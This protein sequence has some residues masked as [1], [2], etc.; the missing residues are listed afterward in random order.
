MWRNLMPLL[1][2]KQNI[3]VIKHSALGDFVLAT[4]PMQAIRRHHP[5][6]HI[7]L[8]TTKAYA[9][10]G[11]DCGW[12]DAVMV[13]TRPKP[14]E[15]GALKILRRELRAANFTRVYD[16]QTS[17]RSSAYYYL[18]Q[19]H[20][21]EWV[22]IVRVGSHYHRNPNRTRLH[23]VDRQREQLAI[24]GITA[25][26]DPNLDWLVADVSRFSFAQKTNVIL[27]AAK[28]P[29]D[30]DPSVATLPQDDNK[31]FVLLVPGG[32]AHRPEKR[33]PANYFATLATDLL[34]RGITPVLI[35]AE[36]DRVVM[37]AIAATDA[38]IINLCQQTNFAEIVSLGRL[39]MG[40]VGNDTGPMHLLAPTGCPGVVLFSAASDPALCAP[41]GVQ[42]D[43]NM[44]IMREND[45]KNLH[46]DAVI[47]SLWALVNRNP[48]D[49]G[50][51]RS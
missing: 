33:W 14:W 39:A 12:F 51:S 35:G 17:R 47:A 31:G 16:L 45:L 49:N 50:A 29:E 30:R 6:A 32:S 43:Q 36:A 7:T 4:G 18:M 25:V 15:F 3:L 2:N 21:A 1:M 9:A 34:T 19:P 48:R 37:D 40:A 20:R 13:D 11:R 41:R 28:D 22:G 27:S 10:W 8:L 42:N 38:R 46:P 44:A 24:A 5:D 23:T 26:P